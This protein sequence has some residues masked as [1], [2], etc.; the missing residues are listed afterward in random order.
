M[1]SSL[2]TRR[3]GQGE[4]EKKKKTISVRKRE[5]LLG[6]TLLV[7]AFE[8]AVCTQPYTDISSSVPRPHTAVSC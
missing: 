2:Y 5:R 7:S 8:A 4:F 6:L 1:G 3:V